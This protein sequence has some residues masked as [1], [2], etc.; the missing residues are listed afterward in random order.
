MV[1]VRNLFLEFEVRL[2]CR[3]ML[4]NFSLLVYQGTKP[5]RIWWKK[6]K[7]STHWDLI[8]VVW[9]TNLEMK[10]RKYLSTHHTNYGTFMYL[11]RKLEPFIKSKVIMF[12]RALLESIKAIGSVLY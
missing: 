2:I 1:Q 3:A 10:D 7:Q 11:V 6:P 9:H 4:I 8:G 5:H 12:V